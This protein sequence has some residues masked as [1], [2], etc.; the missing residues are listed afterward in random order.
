MIYH[1]LLQKNSSC[2]KFEKS[3]ALAKNLNVLMLQCFVYIEHS[4]TFSL[5]AAHVRDR[6]ITTLQASQHYDRELLATPTSLKIR[7]T[8]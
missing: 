7:I 5:P 4:F 3:R 1:Q 2:S 6:C 8:I